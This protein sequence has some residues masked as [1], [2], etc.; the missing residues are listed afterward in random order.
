MSCTQLALIWWLPS[1]GDF[2]PLGHLSLSEELWL[3]HLGV[4]VVLTG[5]YKWRPG[6]LLNIVQSTGQLPPTGN[7]LK[8][9]NGNNADVGTPCSSTRLKQSE[10]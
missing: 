9:P 10:K 4:V 7:Y 2:V 6:R 5:I 3:S 8:A 1:R